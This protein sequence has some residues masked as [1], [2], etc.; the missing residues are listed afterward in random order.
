MLFF[1]EWHIFYD[2]STMV[3]VIAR[4][5]VRQQAI[6]WTNVDPAVAILRHKSQMS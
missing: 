2:N 4:C 5:F 3:Q 1:R 6:V